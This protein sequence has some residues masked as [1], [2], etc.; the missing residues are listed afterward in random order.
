MI[1]LQ[2]L[3]HFGIEVSD[4]TR[5]RH[6]YCDVLG[7]IFRRELGA[8]GLLLRCGKRSIALHRNPGRTPSPPSILDDPLGKAHHAFQVSDADFARARVEFPRRGIPTHG[9]I[10]W[11]DHDCLY[12]LDP[13]GNLLELISRR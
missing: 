2:E 12:F 13:D 3:D 6:F 5:A 11:G 10:D 8:D 9:P 7:L 1:Q 4:L